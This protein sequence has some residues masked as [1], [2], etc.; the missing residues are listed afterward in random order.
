MV[1]PD[2]TTRRLTTS[3][4]DAIPTD[5]PLVYEPFV[6]M[7]EQAHALARE[8]LF[9][10]VLLVFTKAPGDGGTA[11]PPCRMPSVQSI[12][13]LQ[14]ELQSVIEDIGATMPFGAGENVYAGRHDATV[15]D[16]RWPGCTIVTPT[17]ERPLFSNLAPWRE[18]EPDVEPHVVSFL[19]GAVH[20][21]KQ[22]A[23]HGGILFMG[24]ASNGEVL[25]E[26]GGA[27]DLLH[28]LPQ[29]HM[30]LLMTSFQTGQQI[31][32]HR[33]A[34]QRIVAPGAFRP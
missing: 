33:A 3:A 1:T 7:L 4:L 12:T 18:L 30:Q 19:D 5:E 9:S 10:G 6:H 27:I 15:F 23:M 16:E 22:G 8:G 29:L 32:A 24:R 11:M 25:T 34:E 14:L 31:A 17:D 13:A 26:H 21:A 20:A 2:D 28:V